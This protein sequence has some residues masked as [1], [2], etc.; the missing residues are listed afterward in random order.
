MQE[1][2]PPGDVRDWA[3]DRQQAENIQQTGG[4]QKSQGQVADQLF[5]KSQRFGE[6]KLVGGTS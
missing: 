4:A 3:A 1:Q 6:E 2:Q 5:L